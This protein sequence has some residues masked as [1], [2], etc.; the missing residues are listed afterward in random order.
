MDGNQGQLLRGSAREPELFA[1]FYKEHFD[2]IVAYLG[3]S[4]CDPD[5]ALELT[6]E[7]FAQAYVARGRFRG[8]TTAEAEGWI[9]RIARR[10]LTQYFRRGKVARRAMKRLRM[11]TPR[12]DEDA[13]AGVDELADLAGLRSSLRTELQRVPRSQRDALWLRVVEGLSYAEVSDRLGISEQA[14]RTRVSRG[15]R[16]LSG[17]LSGGATLKE[18]RA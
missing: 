15:L 13:R 9:Y 6:A 14:A 8:S 12:V 11:Q 4:V 1:E 5:L 10:Q 7:T 18:V 2:R 16:S 17:A 3:R